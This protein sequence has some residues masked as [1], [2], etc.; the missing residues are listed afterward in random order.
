MWWSIIRRLLRALWLWLRFRLKPRKPITLGQSA[1]ERMRLADKHH[2]L[3]MAAFDFEM[4][5]HIPRVRQLLLAAPATKAPPLLNDWHSIQR[6][7]A[8]FYNASLAQQ[9][10]TPDQLAVFNQ[11]LQNR[12]PTYGTPVNYVPAEF[13]KAVFRGT[14]SAL[15]QNFTEQS[16]FEA[17]GFKAR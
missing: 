17:K 6:A 11:N 4:A 12:Q 14:E 3:A 7:Y 1:V 5:V 10:P 13:P 9:Q 16:E 8:S 15:V 2:A